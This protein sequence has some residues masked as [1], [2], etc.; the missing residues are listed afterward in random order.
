VRPTQRRGLA[1][2]LR[3]PILR[4]LL[5]AAIVLGG[6]YYATALVTG[7]GLF[8]VS[9]VT[10]K[11]NSRLSTGEVLA[12]VSGLR[13]ESVLTANLPAYRRQLV[14]SSWVADATLRRVLPG[15]IE[16]TVRERDPMGLCRLLDHL[17]LVDG[18]GTV[19]DEFGPQYA[20]FDLP[21]IDGLSG[22]PREGAPTIDP[23]R[24]DLAGRVMR[25]LA[26]HPSVARRVSQIDVSD[27]HDAVVILDGETA[28]LHLG[29]SQFGERLQSY[30][31]LAPALHERVPDID[32]VD[33]RF[34]ERVYVRPAKARSKR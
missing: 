20:D 14:E 33:L 19:I 11:G 1:R 24:A 26:A 18:T 12:L 22:P 5:A 8:R 31:D 17:Y 2:L 15:T 29:D 6:A 23:A 9:R 7:T 25:A 34:D 28:L 16:V 4:G 27:P 3:G 21:I 13:G 32:Y 10:V 30:I